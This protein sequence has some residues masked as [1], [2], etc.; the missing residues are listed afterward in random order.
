MSHQVPPFSLNGLF[1]S[2]RLVVDV[3]VS[4]QETVGVGPFSHRS[5][6]KDRHSWSPT[7]PFLRPAEWRGADQSIGAMAMDKEWPELHRVGRSTSI[8]LGLRCCTEPQVRC[9]WT[10][11]PGPPLPLEP[12]RRSMTGAQVHT[13]P[14]PGSGAHEI[15]NLRHTPRKT[16]PKSTRRIGPKGRRSGLDVPTNSGSAE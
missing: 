14:V 7:P 6:G 8:P 4:W 1:C 2:E 13:P 3:H 15:P 10:W 9:D 11:H 12:K 5:K 16:S